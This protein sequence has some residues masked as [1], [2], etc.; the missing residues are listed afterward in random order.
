VQPTFRT[1]ADAGRRAQDEP[2]A[3]VDCIG[4]CVETAGDQRSYRVPMGISVSPNK[5]QDTPGA[6]GIRKRLFSEMPSSRCCVV[7]CG[8]CFH[9]TATG[10]WLSPKKSA[11]VSGEYA[12]TFWIQPRRFVEAATSGPVVTRRRRTSGHRAVRR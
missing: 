2:P 1:Q 3:V 7:L 9:L 11:R 6:P 4:K 10:M 12:P 8:L 5:L